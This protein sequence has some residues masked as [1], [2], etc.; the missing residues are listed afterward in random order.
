LS[1]GREV[2][3]ETGKLRRKIDKGRKKKKKVLNRQHVEQRGENLI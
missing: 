2:G 3:E 1:G